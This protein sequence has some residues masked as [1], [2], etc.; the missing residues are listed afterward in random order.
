MKVSTQENHTD[1]WGGY[2]RQRKQQVQRPWSGSLPLYR[3]ARG[4]V[5][6]E[7]R[8]RGSA[9]RLV[10][11]ERGRGRRGWLAG[12]CMLGKDLLPLLF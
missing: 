7:T 3:T 6:L 1:T 12:L 11:R 4:P 2:S 10:C 8:S 5:C 9:E